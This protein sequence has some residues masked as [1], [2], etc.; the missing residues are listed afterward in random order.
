MSFSPDFKSTS[1]ELWFNVDFNGYVAGHFNRDLAGRGTLVVREK[2]P[3]FV[4]AGQPR[5]NAFSGKSTTEITF[6]TEQIWNVSAE[7]DGVQFT[8][9][10]GKSGER[11][12]PFVFPCPTPAETAA[13][14]AA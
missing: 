5:G 8:T 4:F 12:K 14:V 9:D 3:R 1:D 10:V 11:K 7:G 13:V 6:R 2:E